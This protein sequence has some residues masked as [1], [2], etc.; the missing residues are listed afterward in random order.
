MKAT[1]IFFRG[2]M[3]YWYTSSNQNEQKGI[4]DGKG[5]ASKDNGIANF[6]MEVGADADSLTEVA[7]T[8]SK[9]LL[10]KDFLPEEVGFENVAG[11]NWSQIGD[12]EIGSVSLQA[13]L[14][15]FKFTRIDSY[16]CAIFGFVVAFDA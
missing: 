2:S 7:L 3:D 13:G 5:T 4:Y 14:N 16:N 10:Y 6:K 1:T 15:T 12:V 11:T 9:D 8:A